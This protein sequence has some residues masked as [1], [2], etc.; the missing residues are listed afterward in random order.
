MCHAF[1]LATFHENV[2]LSYVVNVPHIK[3]IRH[4]LLLI[5]IGIK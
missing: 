3:T 1:I 2:G 5:I 4:G